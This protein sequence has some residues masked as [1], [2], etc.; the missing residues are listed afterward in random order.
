MN[1]A[2]IDCGIVS[3]RG[4]KAFRWAVKNLLI[5]LSDMNT[6]SEVKHIKY[7]PDIDGLRAVAVILVVGF[8]A[9]PEVIAGG[10]IGVDIFFVI[11]G[12]LISTIIF[13]NLK[14]NIFS[15]L[16]FYGRRIRRIFPALFV[17][18]ATSLVLGK[19]LLLTEEY[20]FL[21]KHIAGGG[22]LSF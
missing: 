21:G 9:F 2:A 10:Y 15:F 13:E 18:L 11:S 7:R 20:A 14:N 22:Q 3:C 5:I 12:F 16:D 17:V 6:I 19:F 1:R 4:I 8:H